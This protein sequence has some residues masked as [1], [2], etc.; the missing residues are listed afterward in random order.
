MI[1]KR[2]F[3]GAAA[4]VMTLLS[5]CE[6][7]GPQESEQPGYGISGGTAA[8]Q[9]FTATIGA[10]TKTYLQYNDGVYKTVWS[11]G[12]YIYVINSETAEYER[13]P[14]VEGVGTTTATFAGTME[15]DS[16][17]AYFGS[18]WDIE[19]GQDKLEIYFNSYQEAFHIWDS[20][21]GKYLNMFGPRDFPMIAR[22]STKSFEFQNICSV[23]KVSVTG[24]GEWVD[25]IYFTPNDES[26]SVLGSANVSY[27]GDE[28]VMTFL[29]DSGSGRLWFDTWG[30]ELSSE[31][32]DY[33]IVLPAQT[34]YGGFTLEIETDEGSK[35]VTVT[36]DIQ[37]R[38]SRIRTLRV[39][40]SEGIQEEDASWGICGSFT[41]WAD[42]ADIPMENIGDGWYVAREVEIDGNQELKIRKNGL[43]D[44]SEV[45]VFAYEVYADW[46]YVQTNARIPVY[47]RDYGAT[48]NLYLYCYGIYDIWYNPTENCVYMMTSGVSP[49]DLPTMDNVSAETYGDVYNRDNNAYVKVNGMVMAKNSEGFFMQLCHTSAYARHIFVDMSDS[50]FDLADLEVGH[51]IDLYAL[52]TT[53]TDDRYGSAVLHDLQWLSIMFDGSGYYWPESFLNLTDPAHFNGFVSDYPMPYTISGTLVYEYPYYYVMV[54][55]VDSPV[56]RINNPQQLEEEAD[57]KLDDM[58]MQSVRVDGYQYAVY[59]YGVGYCLDTVVSA[60]ASISGGGSTENIVPGDDIILTGVRK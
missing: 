3:L 10:D 16:Y 38:R 34:Y 27:D 6:A 15:A 21:S 36:E 28:P 32:Q 47:S 1:M 53:I 46:G 19:E 57:I 33:Y 24:N 17:M 12:D 49:F 22:S 55:G 42:G 59:N 26:I 25:D 8:T 60:L 48:S 41:D 43:W 51:Y 56:L 37:M 5:A 50:S 58:L 14:I 9:L 54:E 35:I 23:L 4:A 7:I 11:E 31:P 45:G 2:I 44:G 40:Y 29:D 52:K 18:E 20:N 39:D 30:E 13:C